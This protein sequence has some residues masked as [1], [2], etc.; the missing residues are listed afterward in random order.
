MTIPDG[1]S[2]GGRGVIR[3]PNI[4]DHPDIYEL[5]N[6]AVDPDG[7]IERALRRITPLDGTTL[8]DVGCGDGFHLPRLAASGARVIGLEPHL[9]LLARARHRG[10]VLGASAEA[11]PLADGVVDVVH[12]RWAYFFGAGSERGLAEV[13]R[14]LRPGGTAYVIDHDVTRTR[15]GS[16][17]RAAYPAYDPLGVERF[18]RRQGFARERLTVRWAFERRSDLEEV[19]RIEF[20]PRAADAILTSQAGLEFEAGV[21]LWWRR[22]DS[23]RFS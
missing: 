20:P 23:A 15:F 14:V 9:P 12:A 7:V 10:P 17:F 13:V 18:W 3:S 22:Y 6:R 8:L 2:P 21:N 1:P 11:M 4:W 16:W 5:E 19:V